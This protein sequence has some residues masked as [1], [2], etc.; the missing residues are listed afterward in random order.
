MGGPLGI[1]TTKMIL[2]TTNYQ[3]M[4]LLLIPFTIVMPN[5]LSLAAQMEELVNFTL[6]TSV[7]FTEGSK[8][9]LWESFNV[10]TLIP[11]FLRH[12]LVGMQI[13]VHLTW[14]RHQNQTI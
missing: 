6:D 2:V 9:A 7:T 8:S 5:L 11:D 4:Q 13:Y 1:I 12:L 10:A 14:L 3:K